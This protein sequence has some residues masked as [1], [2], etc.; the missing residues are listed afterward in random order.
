M[1]QFGVGRILTAPAP[2]VS[3]GA[4]PRCALWRPR[5]GCEP[6]FRQP[7]G[8]DRCAR[9]VDRAGASNTRRGGE[10]QP[11]LP[12][13]RRLSAHFQ[14]ARG[15][16]H[17]ST[18]A[19]TGSSTFVRTTTGKA[20]APG[21]RKKSPLYPPYRELSRWLVITASLKIVAYP[22][23][24]LRICAARFGRPNAFI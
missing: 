15:P 8:G 4:V 20:A 16:V 24:T 23:N 22:G 14:L 10:P 7:V 1:L 5:K 2:Q 17:Y 6:K 3:R 18:F 19:R 9:P 13:P 21:P 12:Q 11:P